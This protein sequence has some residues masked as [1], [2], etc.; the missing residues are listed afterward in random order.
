[1]NHEHRDEDEDD[2][3]ARDVVTADGKTDAHVGE[4]PRERA[5]RGVSDLISGEEA[6][7]R[8]TAGL[9]ERER[10]YKERSPRWEGER[11]TW[12]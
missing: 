7:A 10:A 4:S 2:Q 11:P 9:R 8:R 1:M 12:T 6:G 5:D 3:R